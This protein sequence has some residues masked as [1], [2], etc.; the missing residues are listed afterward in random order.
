V[1]PVAP[2]RLHKENVSGGGP[3]GFVVPDG[4]ADAL[5]VG[6]TITPFVSYLNQVFRNG[7]FPWRAGDPRRQWMVRLELAKD[8]LPL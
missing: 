3:Y 2:D 5:F 6:E 7:G 1:L 8:L 4:C